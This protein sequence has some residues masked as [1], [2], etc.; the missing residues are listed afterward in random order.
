MKTIG[1]SFVVV[2]VIVLAAIWFSNW[3]IKKSYPIKY[4]DIVSLASEQNNVPK[5]MILAVMREESHF[6][7]NVISSAKA[8]GLMQLMPTTAAWIATKKQIKYDSSTIRDP[9]VNINLG[10]WYLRYLLDQFEN[11]DT[12]AIEAY[13][14][15][16]TNVIA[17]QKKNPNYIEFA[18][19]D[20]FVKRVKKSKIMY[21]DLYGKD[22]ERH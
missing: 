17:W 3:V 2:L 14:A 16:I 11:D 5:N 13:N 7:P 4:A 6:D 12:L 22:W 19:T 15:G 20:N 21:D 10:V 1:K 8:E 18:E 9:E